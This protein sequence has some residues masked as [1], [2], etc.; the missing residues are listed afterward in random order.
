MD[1]TFAREKIVFVKNLSSKVS[2]IVHGRKL[3]LSVSVVLILNSYTKE[4][5]RQEFKRG[6]GKGW[7]PLEYGKKKKFN[8][9]GSVISVIQ[10]V[11]SYFEIE[12]QCE[13][14]NKRRKCC[15]FW[16]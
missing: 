10:V 12:I 16:L 5:S 13:F 3:N 2:E 1:T 15:L 8:L 11:N 14:T 4:Y 9:P 7:I 6:P